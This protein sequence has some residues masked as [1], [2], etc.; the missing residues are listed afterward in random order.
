MKRIFTKTNK[1]SQKE[2]RFF[3]F[4]ANDTLHYLMPTT[5][6]LID[7]PN[8]KNNSLKNIYTEIF[9]I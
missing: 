5:K 9:D 4:N 7:N 3:K 6:R 2:K 8:K 1:K